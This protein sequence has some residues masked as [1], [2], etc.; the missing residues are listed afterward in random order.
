MS[1]RSTGTAEPAAA[2][3]TAKLVS[4]TTV[5]L[6]AE[7][8]AVGERA[9]AH[10]KN[11]RVLT[12]LPPRREVGCPARP[13]TNGPHSARDRPLTDDLHAGQVPTTWR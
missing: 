13:G 8:P 9:F 7:E 3:P 1:E 2:S 5:Q 10:L 12:K 11:Q 4:T 6:I